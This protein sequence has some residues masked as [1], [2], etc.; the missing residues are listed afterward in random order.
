MV[1]LFFAVGLVTADLRDVQLQ[2]LVGPQVTGELTAITDDSLV[3]KQD[4]KE[5]SFLFPDITSVSREL[6]PPARKAK[7]RVKLVD[8]SLVPALT[9]TVADRVAKI[10]LLDETTIDVP[11]R[12]IHSVLLKS[13]DPKG[14]LGKQWND[15]LA[16]KIAGD[17]AVIRRGPE[18]L[19]YVEG[20]LEDV[21]SEV[22][23]FRIKNAVKDAPTRILEGLIYFQ[24]LGR[25]LPS[26]VCQIEDA[27]G[28]R[29]VVRSIKLA[30]GRLELESVAGFEFK[31]A[32]DQFRKMDFSQGNQVY[33]ADLKWESVDWK[34]FFGDRIDS[35]RLASIIKARLPVMFRPR[36]NQTLDGDPLQIATPD[37]PVA[38]KGL[39]MHGGS[40]IVYRLPDG[41]ERFVCEAAMDRRLGHAGNVNLT[42]SGD[43]KTLYQREISGTD[44]PLP[45]NIPVADVGR[46]TIVVD[47]GTDLDVADQRGADHLYLYK[48]RITK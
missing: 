6:D 8:G 7:I 29:W 14:P 5:R 1:S 35:P 48:A 42:I 41:F 39:A 9:Y 12:A 3:I 24:P 19:D 2:P 4:G 33:L 34:S 44:P 37:G 21:S 40:T 27:T 38:V 32:P 31:L 15:I 22:V 20:I 16:K 45:I 25:T 23:K 13:H 26:A 10:G 28:A 11:T 17:V 30:N 18:A 36:V 43:S 47:Y 46:L